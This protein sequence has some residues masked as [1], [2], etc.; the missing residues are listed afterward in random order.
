MSDLVLSVDR[1]PIAGES[2]VGGGYFTANGGKGA[3]QAVTAARI[4]AD[5]TMV[6][7]VG[8]DENGKRIIDCLKSEGIN[9]SSIQ[10][11]A[12][13]STGLATIFLEPN[14]QN[15]IIIN[16]GANLAITH[17]QIDKAIEHGCDA[18]V[19]Q[20]EIDSEMVIYAA[21]RAIQAGIPVIL[22][23]APAKEIELERMKGLFVLT[24]NES[25]A[26]TLTGVEL[27]DISAVQKAAEILK[28]RT[29]AKHVI[30]KMGNKGSYL[31]DGDA[32]SHFESYIVEP[33]DTTAAGDS[34]TAALVYQYCLSGDIHKAIR[35]ANVVGALTV[36]KL[37][38]QSSLPYANEVADFISQRNIQIEKSEGSYSGRE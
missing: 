17:E 21:N 7:C 11:D 14:G 5:V 6:G 33:V 37:G 25:E 34:Y 13:S 28:E 19:L 23:S 20:L 15:R 29:D 4:G 8:D 26:Q 1:M 30:I 35:F 31:Y 18:L 3:N 36:T 10:V 24:P 16:P 9:I 32:I 22:D 38:A 27:S 2:I 12:E